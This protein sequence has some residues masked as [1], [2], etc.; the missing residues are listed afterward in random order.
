MIVSI[1]RNLATLLLSFTVSEIRFII[2]LLLTFFF[3]CQS[4]RLNDEFFKITGIYVFSVIVCRFLSYT[5]DK[6]TYFV[7]VF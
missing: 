1:S 3:G 6:Y 7:S 2:R 4:F 5:G